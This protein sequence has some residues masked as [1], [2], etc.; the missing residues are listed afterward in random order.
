MNTLKPK[1]YTLLKSVIGA[2]TVIWSDQNSPAPALPYWSMRI[3]SVRKIG[4]GYYSQGVT[5]LGDQTILGVREATVAVQR[6]GTDSDLKC[7]ELV[8]NLQKTTVSD[9]FA[10]QKINCYETGD[11][12]NVSQLMDKTIIEPRAAVDLFIRFGSSISD[13][14]SAIETVNSTGNT[15]NTEIDTVFVA[16]AT[17]V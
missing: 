15:D 1:L 4:D 5:E 9:A 2:E 3:Q 8:D 17:V 16:T 10:K 11:V 6:L 7:Q 12:M 14:V 13:N